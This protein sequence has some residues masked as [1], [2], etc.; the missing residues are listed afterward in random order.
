MLVCEPSAQGS[1]SS[2]LFLKLICAVI[3]PNVWRR[4]GDVSTD[5]L[6]LE[7]HREAALANVPF[8]LAECRRRIFAASYD[9]DKFLAT[10]FGRPPRILRSYADCRLPLELTND[11]LCSGGLSD[12]EQASFK[13]TGGWAT[14]NSPCSAAYIRAIHI[15]SEFK[16]DA[17]LHHLKPLDSETKSRLESV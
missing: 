11:Q 7:A 4:L 12:E 1:S 14:K 8:F 2:W 5:L 16:E 9:W 6:A 3:G 10:L 17:L 15:L 13:L